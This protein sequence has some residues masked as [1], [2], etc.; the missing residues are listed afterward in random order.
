[1]E[2]EEQ[3]D[4]DSF[5]AQWA[6]RQFES[7]SVSVT[8]QTGAEEERMLPMRDGIRLKTVIWLPQP[9]EKE[10]QFP[11]I[12]VR[13]CYAQQEP[14][15]RIRAEEFVKRGFAFVYQWCRG[16]GGSEGKWEPNVNERADGLD[17]VT[18]LAGQ[19]FVKNIGYWGDSYLALTGWCMADAVPEKVKTMCLGVY[20]VDRHISAYQ[21]GLFRMDVLT[22]WARENA[23]TAVRADNEASYLFRPQRWMS[24]CG[25][26]VWI[27]TATGSAIRNQGR[28]IG[29]RVFGGC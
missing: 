7:V 22:S 29:I 28:I 14:I 27:G 11:A 21:D 23:G 19:P 16:T 12:L 2:R 3:Q 5:M 18:W 20:G 25:A 1:M 26:C 24:N 13:S 15:L 4:R 17:T 10:E 6:R 9:M 8:R